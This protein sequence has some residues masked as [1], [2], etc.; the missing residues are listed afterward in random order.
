[1]DVEIPLQLPIVGAL[2]EDAGR[3]RM[4]PVASALSWKC[5]GAVISFAEHE[6][7]QANSIAHAITRFSLALRTVFGNDKLKTCE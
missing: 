1:M 6:I 7:I 5:S 4:K 2:R 3:D